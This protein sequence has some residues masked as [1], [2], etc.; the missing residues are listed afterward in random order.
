MFKNLY[1]MVCGV[2]VLCATVFSF[3]SVSKPIGFFFIMF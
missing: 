1:Q 2:T 3:V